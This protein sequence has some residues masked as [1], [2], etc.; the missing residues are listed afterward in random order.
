MDPD[1]FKDN[2]EYSLASSTG[3]HFDGFFDLNFDCHPESTE[4]SDASNSNASN[5]FD[6]LSI[7]SACRDFFN[8]ESCSAVGLP[9]QPGFHAN[10]TPVPRSQRMVHQLRPEGRAISGAQLLALENKDRTPRAFKLVAPSSSPPA[11]PPSTPLN[12]GQQPTAPASSTRRTHRVNKS[13][14]G[15]TAGGSPKMMHAASFYASEQDSPTFGEWTERFKNVSIQSTKQTLPLSTPASARISQEENQQQHI[16]PDLGLDFSSDLF[17]STSQPGTQS[18]NFSSL[19]SS[20]DF[21]RPSLINEQSWKSES[22]AQDF[23]GSGEPWDF[24]NSMFDVNAGATAA[25][26]IFANAHHHFDMMDAGFGQDGLMISFDELSSPMEI[27]DSNGA[28]VAPA[29]IEMLESLPAVS[30]P[31]QQQQQ[32]TQVSPPLLL[33]P[34]SARNSAGDLFRASKHAHR[35]PRLARAKSIPEKLAR[36]RRSPSP[37]PH[38]SSN[39]RSTSQKTLHHRRTR[40][41]GVL[42]SRQSRT[43]KTPRTS[44]APSS[45]ASAVMTTS[46]SCTPG[47]SRHN[48]AGQ[49]QGQGQGQQTVSSSNHATAGLGFVNFTPNDS[50]KI[51]T[52]VAP[53][54]SSKTKARREKEASDRRKKLSEAAERAVMVAGGDVEAMR[55]ELSV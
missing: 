51:L 15:A 4:S 13:T 20:G 38:T 42:S 6:D 35:L 52:G 46:S 41:S 43:L 49:T 1:F 7:G 44:R 19:G 34:P 54:G 50:M 30:K 40:S 26:Q 32:L 28:F 11:T 12:R 3:S 9:F 55:R 21:I 27:A 36:I 10:P 29:S 25:N 5:F 45:A 53:S 8:M 39:P 48:S 33:P 14:S 23:F 31:E 22:N 17:G 37:S 2:D 47:H 24:S 18:S 16:T